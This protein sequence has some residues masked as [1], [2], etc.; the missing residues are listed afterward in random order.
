MVIKTFSG[1]IS[2]SY[3]GCYGNETMKVP[4]S[5]TALLNEIFVVQKRWFEVLWKSL[6]QF[7]NEVLGPYLAKSFG[8]SNIVTG[9][10]GRQG[11]RKNKKSLLLVMLESTEQKGLPAA[12]VP[13]IRSLWAVY[14][15]DVAV[16]TA[17][18]FVRGELTR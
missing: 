16:K 12:I 4:V 8:S 5:V 15:R 3:I 1:P 6:V 2:L 14:L 9:D 10:A 17:P 7:L 18:L 13:S 11:N